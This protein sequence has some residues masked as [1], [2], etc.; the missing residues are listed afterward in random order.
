MSLAGKI[1]SGPQTVQIAGCYSQLHDTEHSFGPL[2]NDF[3]VVL[4][5]NLSV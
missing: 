4:L 1:E 5:H 3:I 2:L